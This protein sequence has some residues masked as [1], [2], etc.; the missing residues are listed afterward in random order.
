MTRQPQ[1]IAI[2]SDY[3]TLVRR[4][5][6]LA[7][8]SVKAA[9]EYAI[10]QE[11]VPELNNY[12]RFEDCPEVEALTKAANAVLPEAW[13]LNVC[14]FISM[15]TTGE[16]ETLIGFHFLPDIHPTYLSI[17]EALS[18]R[19]SLEELRITGGDIAFGGS[20]PGNPFKVRRA[21]RGI[22]LEL[23]DGTTG[24]PTGKFSTIAATSIPRICD[25]MDSIIEAARI[26]DANH[27]SKDETQ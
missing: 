17:D 8:M 19:N 3:L 2:N 16:A 22:R 23:L 18:L 24:E 7:G 25:A 9:I 27:D 14:S 5:A 11:L 10:D 26:E 12:E 20:H 1:N 6:D 15:D 21:G 13:G 4:Y